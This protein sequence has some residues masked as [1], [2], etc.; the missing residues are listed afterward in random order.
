MI[1][2]FECIIAPPSNLH[3]SHIDIGLIQLTFAWSPVAPDCSTVHY[4]ILASNCGSCPPT[5]NYTNVTCAN[6][7]TAGSMCTFAVRTVVCGNI[8]GSKNSSISILVLNT[9]TSR[10]N[11]VTEWTSIDVIHFASIGFLAVSLVVSIVVI[12]T[13]VIVVL[14]RLKRNTNVQQRER[15]WTDTYTDVIQIQRCRER[16]DSN[17]QK[18]EIMYEEVYDII[19]DFATLSFKQNVAYGH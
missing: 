17:V 5:T 19:P 15:S 12:T 14:I 13:I 6:I 4:N 10:S 7:P 1:V 2:C 16:K 8:T 18:G 3:V 11:N 9:L